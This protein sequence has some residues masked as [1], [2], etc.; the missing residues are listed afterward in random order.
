MVVWSCCQ[1]CLSRSKH[2]ETAKE[3]YLI[4]SLLCHIVTHNVQDSINIVTHNVQDSINLVTHD[5]QD[6][7]NLVTYEVEDSINVMFKTV[8]TL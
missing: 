5:V 6:S 1:T 7:I 4:Y 3:T 8:S 2:A